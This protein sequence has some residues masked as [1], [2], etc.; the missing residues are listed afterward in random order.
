MLGAKV[1]AL[2]VKHP[3]KTLCLEMFSGLFDPVGNQAERRR[4]LT[5]TLKLWREKGDD[6]RVANT[7]SYPSDTNRLLDLEGEAMEQAR[8][9]LEIFE[10]LGDTVNQANCFIRLGRALYDNKQP[11]AAEEA[12]LRGIEFLPE[13]GQQF[14]VCQ[15]HRLPDK[16]YTSKGETEKAVY[17]FE[18]AFGIATALGLP[19]TR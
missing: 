16:V 17:H 7:L 19:V 4:I 15:G 8:E 10:R 3:S 14:L 5:H 1:E 18:M 9:A 6:Y 13:N 11:N 2:S 12:A